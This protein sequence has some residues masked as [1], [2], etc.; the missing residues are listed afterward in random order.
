MASADKLGDK[1]F[2]GKGFDLIY[3]PIIHR[4]YFDTTSYRQNPREISE[5]VLPIKFSPKTSRHPLKF[6]QQKD[7]HFP[8]SS[9]LFIL[10]RKKISSS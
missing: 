6:Q 10:P 2:K 8:H 3:T 9:W 1:E 5:I 7:C 4:L